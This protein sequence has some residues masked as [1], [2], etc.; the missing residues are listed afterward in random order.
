MHN[1]RITGGHD[2]NA[3]KPMSTQTPDLWVSGGAI[4]EKTLRVG[5]IECV[6]DIRYY[7]NNTKFTPRTKELPAQPVP[8]QV[9]QQEDEGVEDLAAA[10]GTYGIT[11]LDKRQGPLKTQ[12]L[13]KSSHAEGSASISVGMGSHAEGGA[14]QSL[15]PFSH[16]EGLNT[17]TLGIA[18]HAEGIQCVAQGNYSH[19]EGVDTLATG[20][21]AH[22]EGHLTTASGDASSSHGM[23]SQSLGEASFTIGYT[24][25]A[26]E[27]G[28]F[29]HGAPHFQIPGDAQFS[30]YVFSG[31]SGHEGNVIASFL[32]LDDAFM[33]ISVK[34]LGVDETTRKSISMR[35]EMISLEGTNIS[36]K[37]PLQSLGTLNDALVDYSVT[38]NEFI[39]HAQTKNT[40]R[41]LT[42]MESQ[43]ILFH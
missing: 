21:A 34:L 11:D 4:I 30:R 14:T 32:I 10:L 38:G 20:R 2:F 22:A 33:N 18:S 19:C 24:S 39:V 6:G 12:K 8:L 15:S 31:K 9:V 1:L 42:T 28:Q 41:W 27:K 23:C 7:G 37:T 17:K 5:S 43:Q 26:I 29:A 35:T 16:T 36:D 25:V 40:T 3:L 13:G